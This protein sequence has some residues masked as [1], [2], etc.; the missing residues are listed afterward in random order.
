[1]AEDEGVDARAAAERDVPAL[2]RSR[3]PRPWVAGAVILLVLGAAL[4]GGVWYWTGRPEPAPQ[5][6]ATRA[7]VEETLGVEVAPLRQP[8]APS[9]ASQPRAPEERADPFDVVV[10]PRAIERGE[11]ERPPRTG[12]GG[13]SAP[14]E[15]SGEPTLEERVHA[16]RLGGAV[17]GT[18]AAREVTTVDDTPVVV[19]KRLSG[20]GMLIMRGT[21]FNCALSTRIVSDVPGVTACVVSEDV[22]SADGT[23]VLVDRG[24]R[25]LGL[26]SSG[27]EGG[28]ARIMVMWE[29]L[30]TPQGIVVALESPGAGPAGEAGV[31]GY[32]DRHFM[33]RFG[34]AFLISIVADRV[35]PGG[36]GQTQDG[37]AS[38]IAGAA[39]EELIAEELR[40]APTLYK[41]QGELVTVITARDINMAPVY[42]L[43]RE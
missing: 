42:R 43:T 23:T 5:G 1:M 40:I 10:V 41:H 14:A 16:R 12:A 31:G 30:Q 37:Q 38:T 27:L 35:L 13:S 33:Q 34:N 17:G 3:R 18:A 36:A 25:L 9:V 29:R 24:S 15:Q 11:A 20:L 26:Y 39:F 32:V 22:Y 2:A 8:A 7:A 6:E 4:A 21:A 28:R 19:A